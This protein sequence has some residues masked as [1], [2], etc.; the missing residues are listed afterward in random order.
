M[1]KTMFILASAL[2]LFGARSYANNSEAMNPKK[3]LSVQIY[4]ILK[5]NPIDVKSHEMTA[6]IRFTL[7]KDGE[8]VVLSVDTKDAFLEGYLKNRL[9]YQKVEMDRIEE[10]KIYKVPVRFKA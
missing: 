7:N 5:K 10:G 9:N 8:L 3:S 2:L 1:K 6:Q 4:E